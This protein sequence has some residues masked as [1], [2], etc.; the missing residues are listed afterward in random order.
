MPLSKRAAAAKR[1]RKPVIPPPSP[2]FHPFGRLPSELKV[3]IYEFAL[4]RRRVTLRLRLVR[5]LK[6]YDINLYGGH[7]YPSASREERV[8]ENGVESEPMCV[9]ERLG[10]SSTRVA[11]LEVNQH[12][13]HWVLKKYDLR[14]DSR[15]KVYWR[16]KQLRSHSLF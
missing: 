14:E 8:D 10:A 1:A 15:G 5:R 11:L 9:F 4:P 12:S 16:S 3:M 6:W 7:S 13:R 2:T